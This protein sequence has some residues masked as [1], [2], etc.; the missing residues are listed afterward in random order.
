MPRNNLG[1]HCKPTHHKIRKMFAIWE[2]AYKIYLYIF[3]IIYLYGYMDVPYNLDYKYVIRKKNNVCWMFGKSF[4]GINL[5]CIWDLNIN[6]KCLNLIS[7]SSFFS[8]SHRVRQAAALV[9]APFRR[10]SRLTFWSRLTESKKNSTSCN[11]NITS[12]FFLQPN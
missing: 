2:T 10:G 5:C 12:K 6:K 4:K 11:H 9:G 1:F 7:S 3:M 8:C